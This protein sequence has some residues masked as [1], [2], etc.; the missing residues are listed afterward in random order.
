M[1]VCRER[2]HGS[3]IFRFGTDNECEIIFYYHMYG[4]GV[5]NLQLVLQ[6]EEGDPKT[7]WEMSGDQGNIWHREYQVV[8]NSTQHGPYFLKFTASVGAKNGG[9][10]ALDDVV[11]TYNC[12]LQDSQPTTTPTP[13]PGPLDNCN[14]EAEGLCGWNIDFELNN[15]ERFHLERRD[16]NQNLLAGLLPDQ[17]HLG[18]RAG[19]FLWADALFGKADEFTSISSPLITSGEAICF[20]F[21]FDVRVWSYQSQCREDYVIKCSR[22]MRVSNI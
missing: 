12:R 16:G 17:D 21:W 20:N 5:G 19:H 3:V 1:L 6:P 22:K 7:L 13:G 9:D 4:S 18:D 8:Q 10:I 15:T 2:S 14:F 11:F